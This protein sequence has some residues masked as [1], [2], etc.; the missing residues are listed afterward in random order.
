MANISCPEGRLKRGANEMA[1]IVVMDD[2]ATV[3]NAITVILKKQ[4]HEVQSFE[5][6]QP[7]LDEV[8]F[9]KVDLVVTDLVM[10]TPGDQFALIMQYEGIEVPIIVI[11]ANLNEGRI[12]YLE[13]LG[14]RR[15]LEKPFE[16]ADLL[17]EVKAA[18]QGAD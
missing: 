11:S 18:I 14:V 17:E 2:D 4:G 10:P 3:L 1:K 13:E 9:T 15:I 5:D 12:R 16:V 6:A 8:D 7:A